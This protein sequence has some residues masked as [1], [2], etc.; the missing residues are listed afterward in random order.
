MAAVY[1][2]ALPLLGGCVSRDMP[3]ATPPA[4]SG[5]LTVAASAVGSEAAPSPAPLRCLF[6]ER[7]GFLAAIAA[8]REYTGAGRLTAGMVPHHLVASDMIA[9][10][11]AMAARDEAGYDAVLILSPS[12]FPEN[13]AADV[14][15]TGAG[16]ETPYGP[17]ACDTAAVDALVSAPG[18]G[19]ADDPAAVEADHGAAGLVPF[20]RYYLPR[21]RVAACLVSNRLGGEALTALVDTA[22]S[23]CENNRVLLVASVDCSHYLSSANAAAR[24]EQTKQAVASG[25]MARILT[26]GDA[27]IDSPQAVVTLLETARRQGADITLLDHASSADKLPFSSDNPAFREGVTTYHVYAAGK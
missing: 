25:D 13:C 6:Y 23:L 11:F 4:Q 3:P 24:D 16:W 1:L 26:F 18:L 8:P 22:A 12:H 15:T 20:V 10:F 9:G 21:A 17:V 27:N 14:V 7:D 2:I 5:A 19:A